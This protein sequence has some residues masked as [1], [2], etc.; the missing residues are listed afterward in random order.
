M[1]TPT[2]AVVVAGNLFLRGTAVNGE[3]SSWVLA[4]SSFV[5]MGMANSAKD[6]RYTIIKA[7]TMDC[8]NFCNFLLILIMVTASMLQ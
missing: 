7:I 5:V 4:I 6:Y 3:E 1:P 2:M 8:G